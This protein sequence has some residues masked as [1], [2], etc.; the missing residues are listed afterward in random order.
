MVC[1]CESNTLYAAL[2]VRQDQCSESP[3]DQSLCAKKKLPERIGQLFHVCSRRHLRPQLSTFIC[4]Q[5]YIGPIYVDAIED[6]EKEN[7]ITINKYQS[8]Y[9]YLAALNNNLI[10]PFLSLLSDHSNVY[11][12]N[13]NIFDINLLFPLILRV[14]T[15]YKTDYDIFNFYFYEIEKKL[16][17][18]VKNIYGHSN[19]YECE[20]NY[21]QINNKDLSFLTKILPCDNKIS[22]FNKLF[23]F[24]G[25]KLI[26]G[27]KTPNSYYDIYVDLVDNYNIT[28]SSLT[29]GLFSNAAKYLYKK[30]EYTLDFYADHW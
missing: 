2:S 25:T 17:F 7:I 18:Y 5:V 28:L 27:Y 8:N 6:Y 12:F 19:I 4:E 29:K 3:T 9:A 24:E 16:I 14:N 20:C 21:K 22:L 15:D 13:P 26:S 1:R 11:S 10:I 30:R 23:P